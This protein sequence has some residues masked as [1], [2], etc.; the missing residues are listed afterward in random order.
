VLRELA[1]REAL[2]AAATDNG[3]LLKTR[4]LDVVGGAGS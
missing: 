1:E 4:P 2:A 3:A